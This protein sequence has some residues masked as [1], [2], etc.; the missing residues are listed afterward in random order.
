MQPREDLQ[1][2]GAGS[3]SGRRWS[4]SRRGGGSSG[5]A[6]CHWVRGLS[7]LTFCVKNWPLFVHSHYIHFVIACM[8]S[9][10]CL[11][12]VLLNVEDTVM[13]SMLLP[14]EEGERGGA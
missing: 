11:E 1:L 6:I 12:G 3:N 5:P 9:L 7:G 8:T 2:S 10:M 14:L 4:W 13:K